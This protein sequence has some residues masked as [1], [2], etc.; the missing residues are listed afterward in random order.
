M[1]PDDDDPHGFKRTVVFHTWEPDKSTEPVPPPP[2]TAAATLLRSIRHYFKPKPDARSAALK[3]AVIALY[4][5]TQRHLARVKEI[6]IELES[7]R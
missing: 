4:L 7:K 1:R 2:L 6:A 3:T 5:E